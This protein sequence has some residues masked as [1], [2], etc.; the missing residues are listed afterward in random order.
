MSAYADECSLSLLCTIAGEDCKADFDSYGGF[1]LWALLILYTFKVL[2]DVCDGHL[3]SVLERIVEKLGVPEDVAGATFLAMSSSAPELFHSVVS[4]FVLV[5]PSGLGNI[6]GSALFNLLCIIGVLPICSKE[7]CLRIWWYPTIRDA[8]FYAVSIC[9]LYLVIMDGEVALWEALVMVFTYG[10]YV[11]YFFLNARI[12]RYT[13]W[14][15]PEKGSA[16]VVASSFVNDGNDLTTAA[17]EDCTAPD[18]NMI[19]VAP[20]KMV[21]FEDPCLLDD[22][23]PDEGGAALWEKTAPSIVRTSV[24]KEMPEKIEFI[25]QDMGHVPSNPSKLKAE[26]APSEHPTCA[27]TPRSEGKH[28]PTLQAAEEP[29]DKDAASEG[30]EEGPPGVCTRYDPSLMIIDKTMPNYDWS[31]LAFAIIVAWVAFFTYI[32]VDGANRFGCFMNI[33]HVPMGLIILAA[34][35][36]VPDMMASISVARDGKADMAAANAVG[37]NTFDI[38]L[39]LGLPW[40]IRCGTTGENIEVPFAELQESIAI[41]AAALL[42]YVVILPLNGWVLDKRIGGYMLTVYAF[43]IFFIL[44]RH[45]THFADLH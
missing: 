41:L 25:I 23:V 38:L 3:T 27:S 33:P 22:T 36:S 40:L 44:Y 7:K 19:V 28:E 39:G 17:M 4:T 31:G 13:G 43:S 42:S 37:S 1:L 15:P 21:D 29:I 14:A 24:V 11:L 32:M 12:L 30:S 10:L 35:T 5:S 26:I 9:E 45:Y 16:K 8:C 34:G 6:V 18:S 2:A 20:M